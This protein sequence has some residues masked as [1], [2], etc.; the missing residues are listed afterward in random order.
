MYDLIPRTWQQQLKMVLA[1]W[2]IQLDNCPKQKLTLSRKL[3]FGSEELNCTSKSRCC[4]V[5][6]TH[7]DP[8]QSSQ[9]LM[10]QPANVQVHRLTCFC[11][12]TYNNVNTVVTVNMML[13]CG[14]GQGSSWETFSTSG[15]KSQFWLK[16]KLWDIL[17]Y[18]P[19]ITKDR[20]AARSPTGLLKK[21]KMQ[22]RTPTV[23]ED[24][25][26]HSGTVLGPKRVYVQKPFPGWRS[27]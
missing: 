25:E 13:L 15:Q 1:F 9:S 18:C 6:L 2:P 21:N 4:S 16:E 19:C 5:T 20:G 7:S 24:R 3:G 14:C 17:G 22:H 10:S 27:D 8:P 11:T 23:T 26:N 12:R